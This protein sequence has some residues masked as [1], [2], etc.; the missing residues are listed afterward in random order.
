MRTSLKTAVSVRKRRK[1]NDRSAIFVIRVFSGMRHI[2]QL[3][4]KPVK[5][6]HYLDVLF[7]G[8]VYDMDLLRVP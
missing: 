7:S 1:K 6:Y 4:Q 2:G 8:N 3:F 5:L